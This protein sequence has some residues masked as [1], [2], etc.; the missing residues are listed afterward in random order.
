MA[1]QVS[2]SAINPHPFPFFF[3]DAEFY[4]NFA[5]REGFLEA[6]EGVSLVS[7]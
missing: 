3:V 6:T 4:C 1:E 2:P 7:V 5:D